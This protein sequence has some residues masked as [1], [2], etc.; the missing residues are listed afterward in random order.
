MND[1]RFLD[2]RNRRRAYQ[3]RIKSDELFHMPIFW[4][5]RT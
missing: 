4:S 5:F 3:G 2:R 1:V